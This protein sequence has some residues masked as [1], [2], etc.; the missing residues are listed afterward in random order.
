M[1]VIETERLR[2]RRLGPADAPSILRLLN[3][4]SF[5]RHVG[6]RGVRTLDDA[7][8]FIRNVPMALYEKHGF[9]HFLAERKEDGAMIGTCGLIK[10]DTLEDVDI[11]YSLLPEYW[12]RGYAFEAAA[13]TL[14]YARTTARLRR[15]VAIVSPRN[16]SSLRVLK[17][18]GFAF[19]RLMRMPADDH[20]VELHAIE[21]ATSAPN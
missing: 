20:D 16:E 5:L 14:D 4:P 17:K 3:E 7:E 15:V 6:D 9:G 1:I 18:L 8:A 2:L 19:E 21:L 11:G 13:A 12:S 10:R